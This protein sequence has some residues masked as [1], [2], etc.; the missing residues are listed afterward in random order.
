MRKWASNSEELNEIIAREEHSLLKL[1]P[2]RELNLA[3]EFNVNT[4]VVEE[5]QGLS[6]PTLNS[7]M[8]TDKVIK[9]LGVPWNKN[10]DTLK[11]SFS[12]I[13]GHATNKTPTKREVLSTTSK[14]MTLW[15]CCLH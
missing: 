1:S 13:V 4:D 15:G 5:Y 11:F 6:K 10:S 14:S 2:S 8:L 7:V 9:V 3:Q 12:E